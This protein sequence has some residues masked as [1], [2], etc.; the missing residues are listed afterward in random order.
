MFITIFFIV[1]PL[2]KILVGVSVGILS[3]TLLA[4]VTKDISFVE[5]YNIILN[6]NI[7]YN[8]ILFIFIL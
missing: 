7:F 4:I 5:V 6:K 2:L 8:I 1:S 3:Y